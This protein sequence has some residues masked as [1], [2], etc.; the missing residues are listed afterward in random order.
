M[1]F[2]DKKTVWVLGSGF[3]R[4]LGGPLL[5]DLLSWRGMRQFDRFQVKDHAKQYVNVL[6]NSGLKDPEKHGRSAN[7][8][9]LWADAE[10]FLDF[11]DTATQKGSPLTALLDK[12][13][14]QGNFVDVRRSAIQSVAA[15]CSF[16]Q[17]TDVGLEAWEPFR[18]WSKALT[19]NDVVITFNYD[20]VVER[21]Q[22]HLEKNGDSQ[23]LFADSIVPA[24]EEP[25]W[26]RKITRVYKLHGSVSWTYKPDDP[27]GWHYQ[28]V[29][30]WW[31]EPVPRLPLIG[32]PGPSKQQ[33]KDA[34]FKELWGYAAAALEQADVIVFLG[35]RFPPSDSQARKELFAAI[36]RN[37]KPYL[38]I[39]TVLG[40]N[41][42]H[43]DSV[44]LSRMLGVVLNS[45]GRYE[46]P[47][48]DSYTETEVR[49]R[50]YRVVR[51]PLYV[52]DFFTVLN[53]DFLNG[54]LVPTAPNPGIS[55]PTARV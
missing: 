42:N 19:P 31:T 43:E 41:T 40:P 47:N 27:T 28:E 1:S 38:R 32:M 15:D 44:R 6:F 50:S 4:P 13:G 3:S 48:D 23:G 49:Q 46:A 14:Q 20:T 54:K 9:H 24:W 5:N 12:V 16:D 51:Q 22:K 36:K 37:D 21:L 29:P 45:A 17:F 30:T 33:F 53:H 8:F 26:Q 7:A 55:W 25:K 2:A 35:Y 18:D 52:Q 10:E 11:V 39:H 34:H